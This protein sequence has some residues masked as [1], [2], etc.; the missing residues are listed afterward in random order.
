MFYVFSLIFSFFIT[1][2]SIDGITQVSAQQDLTQYGTIR[3]NNQNWQSLPHPKV[4]S[5]TLHEDG[6]AN[7][8][9]E[10]GRV[11]LQY[12]VPNPYGIQVQRFEIDD[13]YHY[14]VDGEI[15]D[16]FTEFSALLALAYE[17]TVAG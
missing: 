9:T 11:F 14:V 6:S 2:V 12:M 3:F 15:A 17:R 8:V 7:G 10:D 1:F 4:V 5:F 16:S 13:H